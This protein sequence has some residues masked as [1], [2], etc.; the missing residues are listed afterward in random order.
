MT[1]GNGSTTQLGQMTDEL[2]LA[3]S[4][5]FIVELLVNIWAHW[6]TAF[7]SNAWV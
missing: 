3:F 2:N 6:L 5:V 1:L 7:I 4:I